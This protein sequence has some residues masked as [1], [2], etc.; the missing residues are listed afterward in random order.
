MV[1]HQPS[2]GKPSMAVPVT[3]IG[4][5]FLTL[6]QSP[7]DPPLCHSHQ[8]M[9]KSSPYDEPLNRGSQLSYSLLSYISSIFFIE[10]PVNEWVSEAAQS[11]PTLRPHGLQPTRLLGPWDFPGESAGVG[12]MTFVNFLPLTLVEQVKWHKMWKFWKTS[13]LH[14]LSYC[15]C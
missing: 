11:C 9:S 4:K 1:I 7:Y 12:C 10:H 2:N 3:N 5:P 8:N 15:F 6:S 14:F 13:L